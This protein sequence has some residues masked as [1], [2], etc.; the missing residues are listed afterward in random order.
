MTRRVLIVAAVI[1]APFMFL[2]SLVNGQTSEQPPLHYF[3]GRWRLESEVA[4]TPVTPS[5]RVSMVYT[6]ERTT[7]GGVLC[8]SDNPTP[9][10]QQPETWRFGFVA[11]SKLYSMSLVNS[12]GGQESMVGGPQGSV[13]IL[14]TTGGTRYTFRA[15]PD[16]YDLRIEYMSYRGALEAYSIGRAT[17]IK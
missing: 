2:S 9:G 14:S 6:C 17:R 11:S 13:W 5:V 12:Y 3:I 8:R 10:G 7:D 4:A 15:R 1:G 16:S